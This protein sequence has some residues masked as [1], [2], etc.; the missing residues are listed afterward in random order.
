MEDVDLVRRLNRIGRF[1]LA[2]GEVKTSAR[3]WEREG[4]AYTT[5]RNWSLLVR[6]LGGKSP[7]ALQ[8][9]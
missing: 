4:A 5:I 6:Y 2:R 7:E 8:R 1:R 3:R 9:L